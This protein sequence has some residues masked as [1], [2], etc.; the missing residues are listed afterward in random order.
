[1]VKKWRPVNM[2]DKKLTQTNKINCD[3]KGDNTRDKVQNCSSRREFVK[4]ALVSSVALTSTGVL[5]KKVAS[6]I[7]D[8]N[9]QT[10]YLSD[11]LPGDRVMMNREFVLMTDDEKKKIIRKFIKDY[12]KQSS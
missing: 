1:M 12:N 6:L 4:K 5:S 9:S 2:V 8:N 10:A 11:I 3:D 7:P